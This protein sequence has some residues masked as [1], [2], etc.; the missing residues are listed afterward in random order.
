MAHHA[1]NEEFSSDE[2]YQMSRRLMKKHDVASIWL[3]WFNAISWFLLL[4]TGIAMFS[5]PYYQLAPEFLQNIIRGLFGSQATML[6]FHKFLGLLWIF[7]LL[8]YG[9]FGYKSYLYSFFKDDLMLD[10]DDIR[11]LIEKPKQIV[12]LPHQLPPQGIYNAGQKMYGFVVAMGTLGIMVSGLI[13]TFHIGPPVLIRWMI[14]LHF[15]SVGSIIAG[16]IVHIYM[17]AILPEERPAFFSMFTGK[18]N[19]LYAYFHHH[20]WWLYMKEE[21]KRYK[22]KLKKMREQNKSH[23]SHHEQRR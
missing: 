16:L 19:E 22:E 17:A 15:L 4:L 23:D 20:K 7:I 9:I 18:V 6:T 1:L 5:S 2:L 12:G 10:R 11:W 14:V 21:E 3:H 8:P 13:M